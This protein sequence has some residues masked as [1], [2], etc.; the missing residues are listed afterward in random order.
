MQNAAPTRERHFTQK[1]CTPI[2]QAPATENQRLI[3]KDYA[4]AVTKRGLNP[5]WILANCRTMEKGEASERLRIDAKYGG[6]WLEGAN[7]YGQFRPRKE[8]KTP[9][10]KK[11]LKYITAFGEQYD[12]MLPSNPHNPNYWDDLE[13]LK[14]QCY[15]INGHPCLGLTEGMF[16][17]ISGSSN[18]FPTVA[19]AG[20]EMGLSSSKND[21]QGK[22]YLVETLEMLARAGFG[23]VIG[24][25]ADAA[26]KEGVVNAQR[27]LAHQLAKFGNPIY[28]ITGKWE[29][30]EGKGMDD[31]IRDNGFDKFEREILAKAETIEQWEKQFKDKDNSDRK[32]TQGSMANDLI[33]KYRAMLAWNV[34]AKAWYQYQK[35]VPG[36]WSETPVESVN[37]LVIDELN[38]RNAD[39]SYNFVTGVVSLLKSHLR[40]EEWEVIPGK[41]CLQDCVIDIHTL[42]TSEHQPGYRFLSR[43]PFKW[44]DRKTGCEP[45]KEWLLS[46][47]GD[48]ADWVEVIR[49]AMNATITERGAELQR[50]MELVGIGGSGKGTILRLIQSL[51]GKENYAVT[52]LKHL[53]GGQFETATFFGKKAIFVTDAEK[54]EKEVVVLKAL[55]GGDPIRRE[56]KHIQMAG[57]FIFTGVAWVAA[58]AAIQSSD[59]SNAMY[60]RRLPMQFDRYVAPSD[61]RDLTEEFKPYLPGLLAWVL[62][63]PPE[64][65]AEYVRN[66]SK[67]VPSLG[68]ISIDILLETNPLAEWADCSLYYQSGL[69]VKVGNL[70][71]NVQDCLY[72]NYAEWAI[73]N[74]RKPLAVRTFTNTLLT[75]FKGQGMNVEKKVTNKGAHIS[76]VGIV[77]PGHNFPLLF[78]RSE[79]SEGKGEE[80]VRDRVRDETLASYESEGSEVK[81]EVS[82]DIQTVTQCD[83]SLQK[84]LT[85]TPIL[86]SPLTNPL[87]DSDTYLTPIPNGEVTY[88]SPSLTTSNSANVYDAQNNAQPIAGYETQKF[89]E[90]L[91]VYPTTGKY[92]GKQCK[93]S[94]IANGEIW[95]Y[96]NTT[97][98]G[99]KATAYHQGEL[100]LT[101][102]V[103]AEIEY[104]VCQQ[105]SIWDSEEYLEPIDD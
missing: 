66:T 65:V 60:R 39:Y 71:N 38:A 77:Q 64:E 62:T 28:S 43:I 53:E 36:V 40:I 17:A 32:I 72:A 84:I 1:A 48:R 46:T 78:S 98:K 6:I 8:F 16:T 10:S 20:V 12:A 31:Y 63:M 24:F 23:W 103:K 7:G 94:A 49:A 90:G 3:D 74:G 80:S 105:F 73:D 96:P 81:K 76:N 42:E 67:K 54:Y 30:G 41:V 15:I 85:E 47:C 18:G 5:E 11:G 88:P 56:I 69:N 70:K 55:T 99:V 44:A 93:I 57:S 68:G 89:R 102:P 26:R 33:E 59:Y 52:T 61:R 79:E 50:Y 34:A 22:R 19:I 27:K 25:D 45:I 82:L 37:M 2:L 83:D 95:A 101:P 75:L 92:Q 91:V 35:K 86:S 100:S 4:E 97:Q 51:L 13:T 104:E 9:T 58:N 87:P 14:T 21:I 29:E